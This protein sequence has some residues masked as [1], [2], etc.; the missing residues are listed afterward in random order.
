LST[1]DRGVGAAHSP[2]HNI[3]D[4]DYPPVGT[5]DRTP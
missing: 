5:A 1:L 4:I 3:G 2:F